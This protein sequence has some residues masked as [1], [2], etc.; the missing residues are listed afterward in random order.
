MTENNKSKIILKKKKYILTYYTVC[1]IL[2][3]MTM[4]RDTIIE[5]MKELSLNPNQLY[6]IL[7]REKRNVPRMTIYDF[8]TGK[9][10]A[11][12]EVASELMKVL[13]LEVRPIKNKRAR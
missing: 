6:E 7:K 10:D 12:T 1:R 2:Y 3:F 13:D 5:R 8:L 9:T 4:I 11:R